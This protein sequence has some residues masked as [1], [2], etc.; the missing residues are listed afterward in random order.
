[1]KVAKVASVVLALHLIGLGFF[2]YKPP[3]NYFTV[4]CF[5]TVIV[6][7]M[8]FSL[9]KRRKL[10]LIA[11]LLVQVAIQQGAYHVWLSRETSLWWPL[12]QFLALQYVLVLRLAAR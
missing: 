1:V 10:G 2:F 9:S 11:G 5:S 12:L 6:W 7:P 8:T 4:V 3:L